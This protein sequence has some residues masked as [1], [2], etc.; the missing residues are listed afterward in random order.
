MS[1]NSHLNQCAYRSI[2]RNSEKESIERSLGAI[3][4]RLRRY[5]RNEIKR[6][7]VF[8]SYSRR[9]ILPRRI[10][11]RSDVDL[12]VVFSD[13]GSKPQTYLDRL[14]RFAERNYYASEIYQ[15][16]PTIVLSLNHIK[17]ELVPA[18]DSWFNGLQIPAPASDFEDWITTNPT[19][20][21]EALEAK[22]KQT[23]SKLKPLIRL[24]KYWNATSG[25]V[26]PSYELEQKL[27]TYW[28]W[29]SKNLRDYFYNSFEYLD[30]GW[31]SAQWKIDK[32]KRAKELVRSSKEYELRQMPQSA[33]AQIIK[34]LPV[35]W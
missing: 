16:N 6:M 3:K 7:P 29:N 28:F 12:M 27:V 10:D 21:N 8:G 13:S 32:L 22:N 15:S 11:D 2:L 20:F 5:F 19:E 24:M 9:T 30:L 35:Y 33:E 17:F 18:I 34:L 1:V 4:V 25:Y 31:Y 14:R 26:F 23:G